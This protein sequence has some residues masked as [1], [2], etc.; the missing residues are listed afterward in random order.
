MSKDHVSN[1]K[2]WWAIAA[3]AVLIAA[4]LIVLTSGAFAIWLDPEPERDIG[5]VLRTALLMP[6]SS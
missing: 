5:M 4:A 6:A 2:F 1:R 3:L